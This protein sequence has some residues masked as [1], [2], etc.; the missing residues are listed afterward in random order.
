[1]MCFQQAVQFFPLFIRERDSFGNGGNAIPNILYKQDTLC[2]R[3]IQ[4]IGEG[5]FS[6]AC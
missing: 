5:D 3:H 1:M 4:D 2:N 6:H